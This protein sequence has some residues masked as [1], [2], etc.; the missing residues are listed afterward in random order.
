MEPAAT[1]MSDERFDAK[2]DEVAR[3]MTRGELPADFRA[4]V[5]ARIESDDERGWT[6]RPAWVLAPL[7][8]A[9]AVLLA[10]FVVRSPWRSEQRVSQ[11]VREQ[12]TREIGPKADPT[13]ATNTSRTPATVR[14]KPDTAYAGRTPA[15]TYQGGV[16]S[17]LSPAP[18]QIESIDVEAMESM[19]V[20][21]LSV[22]AMESIDVPRLDVAPLE[23][24]AIAG[25]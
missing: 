12:V 11:E 23:V 21:P 14:P 1:A 13:D 19:E 18:I 17:D 16:A 3:E 22:D 6:R 4:H 10:V 15:A 7:A 5:I 8:V 9:A 20:A 25:E 2:I 24:P